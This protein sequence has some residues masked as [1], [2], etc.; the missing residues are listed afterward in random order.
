MTASG[1]AQLVAH[2]AEELGA[3]PVELLQRRQVLQGDHDRLDRAVL[4]GDR[5]GVD[6]RGHAAPVGHRDLD[7]LGAHRLAAAQRL[8][9]RERVERHLAP[10]GAPEGQHLQQLLG[11][12]ARHAQAVHQA[13]RLAVERLRPPAPGIEHHHADRRGVD[14]GLEVGPRAP[15]VA[16]HPRV[17]DRRRGL[18][19]EQHQHLLVLFVERL[20]LLLLA[21]EEVADMLAQ[22]AHRRRLQGLR[23]RE[24]LAVAERAQIGRQVGHPE[25]SREGAQMLEEGLAR[26]PPRHVPALLVGQ[27]GGDEVLERARPVDGGDHA[28][29]RAGQRPG[30]VDRLAQHGVEVEAG[31]DA[32][33]R[34]A[35][36]RDA[37]AQRRVLA[38]QPVAS[39]HRSLL[40]PARAAAGFRPAGAPGSP[41]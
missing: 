15:L 5:R 34:R 24:F 37:L 13:Q 11:R 22:V 41:P 14:Q 8:G 30:A 21:E 31:A 6:Q 17:G 26:R 18:R 23:Q 3:L 19:R 32:Q 2:Q 40:L 9:Q 25:R 36:R 4:A 16:V 35:E 7:L 39:V 10:V 20:A 27:A 28:V 38:F 1:G 33:D 29:A 12:P